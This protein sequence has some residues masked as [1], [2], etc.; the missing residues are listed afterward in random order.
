[1][2][3][4][5]IQFDGD[6]VSEFINELPPKIKRAQY[7]SIS[8][9]T[10]WAKIQLQNRMIADTGFRERVFKTFRVKKKRQR[11]AGYVWLGYNEVKAGYIGPLTQQAG[12]ASVAGHYFEGGFIAKMRSG[13]RGIFKRA[14]ITEGYRGRLRQPIVHQS[15]E[16]RGAQELMATLAQETEQ[17][18]YNNF[19][20]SIRQ[21]N[22][23]LN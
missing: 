23:Y 18:L 9:A 4:F 12:G 21:L 20:S 8:E 14:E 17:V 13:H 1:M 2:S 5:N 7:Q 6:A 11:W 3:D 16:I 15:V 19:A 10:E 22:P